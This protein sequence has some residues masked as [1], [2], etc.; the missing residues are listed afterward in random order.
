M[1]V[2]RLEIKYT[3]QKNNFIFVL[4][5]NTL[6][7]IYKVVKLSKTDLASFLN[8]QSFPNTPL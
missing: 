8:F 5:S 3:S 6:K 1:C 4:R 7:V 2:T